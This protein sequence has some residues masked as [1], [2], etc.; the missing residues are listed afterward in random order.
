MPI[1]KHQKFNRPKKIFDI[2]LIKEENG[3][4]KRYGLKNRREVWKANFAIGKIRNL[5]KELILANETEKNQF[6]ERQAKKGFAVT[7]IADILGLGKEDYLKRR[8]ES[9]I[10]AK[11]LAK[12]HKQARQMIVHRHVSMGGNVINSPAHLTTIEEEASITVNFDIPKEKV[13]SDEEKEIL[14][15]INHENKSG[16]EK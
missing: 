2:A 4:I 5:A 6:I 11:K 15:Q 9:I 16:E 10:V 3:L 7:S 8:L 13:I 14:K 1:R 12:T